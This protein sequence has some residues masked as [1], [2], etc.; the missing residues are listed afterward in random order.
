MRPATA[1]F[2]RPLGRHSLLRGLLCVLLWLPF[3]AVEAGAGLPPA[4][5]DAVLR[6]EAVLLMRHA[7]APG[8]GDPSD[9]DLKNCGTQRNL[10]AEGRREAESIGKALR[11]A[12]LKS[13]TVWSSPW[14]R[15]QDTARLLGF[16]AP[17]LQPTLGSFFQGYTE[18]SVQTAGTEQL[19][20]QAPATPLLLVTHQVNITAL[21]RGAVYP[22]SGELI[23]VQR[24]APAKV[25][26]SWVVD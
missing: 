7:A 6:G 3:A 23:A 11:A 22:R 26:G 16:G 13:L 10:S 9:F 24:S 4:A 20:R 2:R 21:T 19:L 25:L 14:C 17:R 18:E 5:L 15:C 8:I 1:S 12:G